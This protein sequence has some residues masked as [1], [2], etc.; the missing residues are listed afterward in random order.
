MT[1]I[2][3]SNSV[4]LANEFAIKL[5]NGTL[6][7]SIDYD[8]EECPLVERNHTTSYFTTERMSGLRA[9][10]SR[11]RLS[12]MKIGD[13]ETNPESHWSASERRGVLV[14]ATEFDKDGGKEHIVAAFEVTRDYCDGE[15]GE[16]WTRWRVANVR[17]LAFETTLELIPE[18]LGDDREPIWGTRVNP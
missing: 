7:M 4:S 18:Y 12:S 13:F 16:G 10:F 8:T 15:R 5:L 3:F 11:R 17:I 9:A 1:K 2:R 14:Y 6:N